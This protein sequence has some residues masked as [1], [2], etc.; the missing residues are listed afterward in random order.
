M[1]RY[2]GENPCKSVW[3][4][5]DDVERNR[6]SCY[7]YKALEPL[8]GQ[9]KI[10]HFFGVKHAQPKPQLQPL[11]GDDATA[12]AEPQTQPLDGDDAISNAEPERT[13]CQG[14]KAVEWPQPFCKSYPFQV[15]RP[16]EAHRVTQVSW[17]ATTK[18][19]LVSDA[20][21]LYYLPGDAL[22]Y[23]R[24]QAAA[25]RQLPWLAIQPKLKRSGAP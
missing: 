19:F 5:A 23:S 4:A 2:S 3:T 16:T 13:I 18:G 17:S 10:S 7:V 21:K 1:P 14:W 11:D 12:S 24:L 6:A 25:S 8:P 15:H 9:L 20:C 22:C